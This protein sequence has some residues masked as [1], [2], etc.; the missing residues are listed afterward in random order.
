MRGRSSSEGLGEI[1]T[2]EAEV[3]HDAAA[4]PEGRAAGVGRLPIDR[5]HIE[6]WLQRADARFELPR[7][8]RLLIHETTPGLSGLDMPAGTGV[9]APGWDGVVRSSEGTA[10]LPEGLSLWEMSAT[11][12]PR[13]K[14]RGDYGKRTGTPD[15]SPTA[16]AVYVG[17]Y[18]HREW[19]RAARERW[20]A[21]GRA[22]GRWRDVV[23][24]G[25]DELEDWLAQAP[26]TRAWFADCLG[27]H[28][29]GYRAARDWW[30]DWASLTSPAL[31]PELLIAGRDAQTRELLQRLGGEPVVTTV[32]AESADEVAAFVVAAAF[33]EGG[34]HEGLLART[35]V[36]NDMDS[37]RA[38]HG[39]RSPLIL[40]PSRRELVDELRVGSGHHVVVPALGAEADLNLPRI[41]SREATEV[42][43][44][45]GMNAVEAEEAGRLA[46]RCLMATRIRLARSRELLLPG[47]AQAPAPRP[48]RAVLL[49]GFWSH[50]VDGD[51][52]ILAELAGEDYEALNERLEQIGRDKC[53]LA[54]RADRAWHLVSAVDAWEML[55]SSITIDDLQR[56]ESAVQQVLG[57][58]LASLDRGLDER[59][60]GPLFGRTYSY[61]SELREGLARSLALL[62]LHGE[63]VSGT[64]RV[65]GSGWA[66]ALARD[67]LP[68]AITPEGIGSWLSL[69]DVL[70]T[71]AEAA[72]TV[73]LRA[74]ESTVQSRDAAP[75]SVVASLHTTI[76][77]SLERIAWC[78]DNFARAVYAL[79]ALHEGLTVRNAET[80]AMQRLV[81]MFF[82]W[83][84]ISS[85]PPEA[86]LQV[87]D[88]LRSRHPDCAWQLMMNL[89]KPDALIMESER[90][91]YRDWATEHPPSTV[92]DVATFTSEVARLAADTAGTNPGRLVEV[93]ESLDYLAPC[94]AELML[95]AIHS[96]IEQGDWPDEERARVSKAV[97]GLIS[98]TRIRGESSASLKELQ[99][100]RLE[101][102]ASTLESP[103][104]V[105]RYLWLFQ[106]WF[107]R[108]EG[109]SIQDGLETHEPRVDEARRNAMLDIHNASGLSGVLRLASEPS[110]E[111]RDCRHF[112][113][114][115][116]ADSL[117]T[118]TD[119]ELL[120]MLVE[121][122]PQHER[123][124]AFEYYA[125]RFRMEGWAWFEQLL[126]RRDLTD[127][128]RARL[129]GATRD[130]PRAWQA[131]E[132]A[133]GA[134]ARIFWAHFVPYG[135]GHGFTHVEF[136]AE[137]LLDADRPLA[138][139]TLLTTYTND[140]GVAD[141]EQAA[142]LAARA[143]GELAEPSEELIS[144]SQV[145][146]ALQELFNLMNRHRASVGDEMIATLEWHYLPALGFEPTAAS[147]HRRMA[148]DP[149]FF[150]ELVCSLYRPRNRTADDD[151]SSMEPPD[152]Q[153]R[154]RV[155]RAHLL[156]KSWQHLPGLRDDGSMDPRA[157]RGWISEAR[158]LLREADRSEVG[159]QHI[160]QVL[161]SAPE[162]S[163]GIKPGTAI[164][165]L[166]EEI[167]CNQIETGL[168]LAIVNSRGATWRALDAGGDQERQLAADYHRQA[169]KLKYQ[170]PRTA[171]ILTGVARSYE[172]N[173][174]WEDE[175][176]ERFRTGVER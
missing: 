132:N 141:S 59:W 54:M 146:Y 148:T 93:V 108:I 17:L 91:L 16:S 62:A 104:A 43:E 15:G 109:S 122:G 142:Q 47:W 162:G 111:Q 78:E 26:V 80:P 103:D 82:P 41:D 9:D 32:R 140:A 8:I 126:A 23:A 36:V 57:E 49:A 174:R 176:A 123:D 153:T 165:D 65:D 121:D 96:A 13:G 67:L 105:E 34:T 106:E 170:W 75:S 118:E 144:G 150:V 135:L 88:G 131:A 116:L 77:W 155:D 6:G 83:R 7:L 124:L 107:P 20:T 127:Y 81:G 33:S 101:A 138:A 166:L 94:D 35:A 157:L 110:V 164:R 55:R 172:Y 137:R 29:S 161:W 152:A 102:I 149:Q 143:L 60:L 119:D 128:Q 163:D 76:V 120:E 158:R 79:A 99:L 73:F 45:A 85:V 40:V 151:E 125:R 50:A 61:S 139:M 3:S 37:W 56:L 134:I 175:D 1:G 160:G 58:R 92:A 64:G 167:C 112:V 10:W 89:L 154:Q 31:P 24:Y 2:S 72:P 130:Y 18:P 30:R 19:S 22:D 169:D 171:S 28:P 145:E 114:R 136:V 4:L 90:P 70:P 68:P 25:L 74:L 14:A 115:A 5:Q 95:D 46:R 84:P 69:K 39:W 100:S 159:E 86:R 98:R 147:L 11:S 51:R 53:P 38:L 113:A 173:A 133:T 63:D 12:A 156:L 42:L 52:E 168:R 66:S 117:G 97:Y 44:R 48:V 27:L 71:L 129:L 21:D 87:L